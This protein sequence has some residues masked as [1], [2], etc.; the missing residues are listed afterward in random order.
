[1]PSLATR[2]SATVSGDGCLRATLL[3]L[4]LIV[5]SMSASL[6]AQSNQTVPAGGS[7]RAFSKTLDERSVMRS[8][9]SIIMI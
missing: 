5:G 3:T 8:A 9:S 4:D 6:G 1:M 7:S 2:S